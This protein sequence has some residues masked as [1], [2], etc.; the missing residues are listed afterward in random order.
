L[1]NDFYAVEGQFVLA[2]GPAACADSA[3]NDGDGLTDFP[4]D[5]GC[6]DASDDFE[7]S[8]A[9]P[10]DDGINNDDGDLLID[11]EDPGCRDPAWHTEGPACQDGMDNDA[12]GTVDFDGGISIWGYPIK[13]ADP[14]CIVQ[15][16]RDTNERPKRCGLGI[17]LA[18]LLRVLLGLRR[19]AHRRTLSL[20]RL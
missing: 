1:D 6:T 16:A 17:E 3:D 2:A 12:D 4:D 14:D 18:V 7:Q 9:L 11:M 5:P 20:S 8:P 10:C 15:P 19:R 13:A